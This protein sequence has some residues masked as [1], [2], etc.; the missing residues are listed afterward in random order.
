MHTFLLSSKVNSE[1]RE[2]TIVIGEVKC[3]RLETPGTSSDNKD[4]SP[5][6]HSYLDLPTGKNAAAPPNKA[7]KNDIE[8]QIQRSEI[9]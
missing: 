1:V 6:I 9:A 2:L 4:T 3:S 8:D 7:V 5:A